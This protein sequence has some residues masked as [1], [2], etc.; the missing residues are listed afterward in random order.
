M[1]SGSLENRLADCMGLSIPDCSKP[2]INIDDALDRMIIIHRKLKTENERRL[3]QVRL[4]IPDP[5]FTVEELGQIQ[6][7]LQAASKD[8]QCAAQYRTK[9]R[10][11]RCLT[12]CIMSLLPINVLF[13]FAFAFSFM[14]K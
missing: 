12:I 13:F 5:I 10:C 9:R 8:L 4:G 14:V 2:G 7:N 11:N 6:K 3:K 1:N